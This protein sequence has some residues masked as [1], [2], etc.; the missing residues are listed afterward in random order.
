ML[1]SGNGRHRRIRPS[2]TR[3]F[4]AAAGVTGAGIA[5]P[6]I[7]SGSAS[8]ASVSTWDKVAQCESGGDWAVNTGNGFYGGLQF[9][10]STWAAYGGTAYADR[11]DLA[12]K[13]QQIAVAEQVLD[14]QGPG[15]WPVCSVKAGLS[16]GG[17]DAS[18]DTG[19]STSVSDSGSAAS[20]G[21]GRGDLHASGGSPAGASATEQEQGPSFDGRAGWDAQ[22]GVYWFQQDGAWHWTSHR[23]VYEQRTAAHPSARQAVPRHAA[24]Q[25]AAPAAAAPQ[26]PAAPDAGRDGD[27]TVRTG[28]S[29][30]RIAQAHHLD[31]WK[32]LYQDNRSTVGADP[33]LILPGQVLDLG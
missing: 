32:Q 17:P 14:S 31:G 12:T 19:G 30:S 2:Q 27:Y 33:D 25:Q 16:S 26:R 13:G 1:L 18:V 22:D 10:Q 15:A 9:T 4:V 23:S 5:L 21:S 24:P 3:K 20:R 29:L 8:A 7:T 28:D 11:A 6:L